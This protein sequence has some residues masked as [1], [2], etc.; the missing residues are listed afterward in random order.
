MAG[1]EGRVCECGALYGGVVPGVGVGECL[2]KGC[3]E[4]GDADG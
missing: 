3:W 2:M 4:W 1:L